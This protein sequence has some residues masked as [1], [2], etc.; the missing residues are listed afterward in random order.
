MRRVSEYLEG[1]G[2]P[3][4]RNEIETNVKGKAAKWRRLAIDTLLAEGYLTE[5]EG[6]RGARL[7]SLVMPFTSSSS[8]LV[9]TSSET[10]GSSPLR[11]RLS[12]SRGDEDEDEVR[13]EVTSS[14]EV[15]R[16]AALGDELGL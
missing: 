3:A 7:V 16:L 14:D 6:A 13:D 15:E 4:S 1:K 11:L 10:N 5:Q 8:D 9:P 12:P 2:E